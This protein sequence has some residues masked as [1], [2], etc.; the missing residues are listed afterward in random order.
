MAT[1]VAEEGFD[2]PACDLV[3]RYSGSTSLRAFVQS[4][5][6]ARSAGSRFVV[7]CTLRQREKLWLREQQDRQVGELVRQEA[8]WSRYRPAAQESFQQVQQQLLSRAGGRGSSLA[9]QDLGAAAPRLEQDAGLGLDSTCCLVTVHVPSQLSAAQD[10][11][12]VSGPGLQR[13]LRK[14]LRRAG[15][16]AQLLHMEPGLLR[17][18]LS[19]LRPRSG[20]A[21]A[22]GSSE[23]SS[24]SA[25]AYQA[26]VQWLLQQ[27]AA[28]LV[29]CERAQTRAGQGKGQGDATQLISERRQRRRRQR[30]RQAAAEVPAAAATSAGAGTGAGADMDAD[31]GSSTSSYQ[32]AEAGEQLGLSDGDSG[33]SSE[34]MHSMSSTAGSM[35]T[36]ADEE[37]SLGWITD[38]EVGAVGGASSSGPSPGRQELQQGGGYAVGGAVGEQASSQEAVTTEALGAESSGHGTVAGS[39]M[40]AEQGMEQGSRLSTSQEA[41][42]H[43][44]GGAV[45]GRS[46]T[47]SQAS[48]AE[49]L[50][51]LLLQHAQPAMPS[52]LSYS[53]AAVSH[54]QHCSSKVPSQLPLPAASFGSIA[55]NGAVQII[56]SLTDASAQQQGQPQHATDSTAA[57][58]SSLAGS[59][60]TSASG[61]RLSG[62]GPGSASEGLMQPQVLLPGQAG[63]YWLELPAGLVRKAVLFP[64][65]P[66]MQQACGS[67]ATG[68]DG[69]EPPSSSKAAAGLEGRSSKGTQG[70]QERSQQQLL[71]LLQLHHPPKLFYESGEGD[72]WQRVT[73]ASADTAEE[74]QML[75][76]AGGCNALLLQV[77]AADAGGEGLD[78]VA[79]GAGD[80]GNGSAP[81]LLCWALQQHGIAVELACMPLP[82]LAAGPAAPAAG[83]PGTSTIAAALQQEVPQQGFQASYAAHMIT[84]HF[85]Q[86]AAAV[87]LQLVQELTQ[88]ADAAPTSS[89]GTSTSTSVAPAGTQGP[90]QQAAAARALQAI[91]QH[92]WTLPSSTATQHLQPS[93]LLHLLRSIC[94]QAASPTT[95]PT[96]E[97]GTSS[98]PAAAGP[99]G[100]TQPVLSGIGPVLLHRSQAHVAI[101]HV[102]VTP[103]RVLLRPGQAS[104]PN[105]LLLE[106]LKHAGQPQWA[107]KGYASADVLDAFIIVSFRWAVWMVIGLGPAVRG[108]ANAALPAMLRCFTTAL[109]AIDGACTVAGA[110][111]GV[112]QLPR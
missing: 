45:A 19:A 67:A 47:G 39:E 44:V 107:G 97:A 73:A 106:A 1:S 18:Q 29:R 63:C 50:A 81:L 112:S 85:G 69:A 37:D 51:Q 5:G 6:R 24:G 33:S 13:H 4:R 101:R 105:L 38:D 57:A 96:A 54:P 88:P 100:S 77:P 32:D 66:G 7:L 41:A 78:S 15:V 25:A 30:Q 99:S 76:A 34:S 31:A 59:A 46:I 17:L 22:A 16:R 82:L 8:Q 14:A 95:A 12:A 52:C 75:G 10:A 68:G 26:E 98:T 79:A 87:A 84:S 9:R 61:L 11:A 21:A 62:K 27:L 42:Q 64:A 70:E 35:Y 102:V 89:T 2:V 36:T 104:R 83:G 109:L 58:P 91:W 86:Q 60:Y 43:G 90:G 28:S 53:I 110:V 74:E 23:D 93:S 48:S 20:E 55:A 40:A 80:A 72:P 56:H 108:W 92:L 94:R 49:Q 111:P 65:A 103:S 71:L 3:V